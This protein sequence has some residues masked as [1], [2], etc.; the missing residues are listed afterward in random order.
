MSEAPAEAPAPKRRRDWDGWAA[1]AASFAAVL[2]LVVAAYTADL[3]RKQ[4]RAQVWPRLQFGRAMNRH[5]VVLNKGTG[6]ARV[7]SVRVEVD[8][9]KVKDWEQLLRAL[10]NKAEHFGQS[11]LNRVV[12]SAGEKIEW[13]SAHDNEAGRALFQDVFYD[14]MPRLGFEI[15]YC[16]V[17]DQCWRTGGGGSFGE[18]DDER[19]VDGCPPLEGE[20]TQ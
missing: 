15:C 6:P 18:I 14:K 20:F 12:V 4:V 8:G 2:A 13:F 1:V 19:E 11:Q 17:L 5:M 16:S 7:R 9:R 3:Q 10:G